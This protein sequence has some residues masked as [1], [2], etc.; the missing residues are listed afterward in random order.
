MLKSTR[1]LSSARQA[2]QVAVCVATGAYAALSVPAVAAEEPTLQRRVS[3]EDLNLNQAEDAQRLYTRLRNAAK[4]ACRIEPAA[5]A[6]AAREMRAC[7][8]RALADAIAQIDHPA[9]T[10]LHLAE[11]AQRL[12]RRAQ[13]GEPQ[14]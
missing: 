7:T 12:A 3:Y 13:P 4:T 2:L 8:Q 6:A 14:T 10:E 1:F 11:D 9:L 5:G